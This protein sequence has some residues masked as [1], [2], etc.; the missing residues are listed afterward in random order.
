[1]TTENIFTN[2]LY[3]TVEELFAEKFC[4]S[5]GSLYVSSGRAMEDLSE[6]EFFSLHSRV[7]T[8]E[9]HLILLKLSTNCFSSPLRNTIMLQIFPSFKIFFS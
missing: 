9:I 8:Q 5:S 2:L 7:K 1:M 3:S 6:A 4:T